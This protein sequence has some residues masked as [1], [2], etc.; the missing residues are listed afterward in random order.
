[1]LGELRD[2][3]EGDL[4]G[5]TGHVLRVLALVECDGTD[6][7]GVSVLKGRMST[8]IGSLLL[9]GVFFG[10]CGVWVGWFAKAR[11]KLYKISNHLWRL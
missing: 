7:S 9:I 1:M 3:V 6:N 2:V 10:H 5:I 11:F 4:V 8:E